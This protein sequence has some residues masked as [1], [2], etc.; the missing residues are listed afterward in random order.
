[1]TSNLIRTVIVDDEALA[2]QRLRHLLREEGDFDL[3]AECEGGA[4]AVGAIEFHDPDLVFLDVRMPEIDGFEVMARAGGDPSRAIVFVTAHEEYASRAFDIQA[5][6]YLLKPVTRERFREAAERARRR[7]ALERP[8]AATAIAGATAGAA[9]RYVERFLV[10]TGSRIVVVAT[11]EIEWVEGAG[12]YLKLHCGSANY[13]LRHTLSGFEARLDPQQFFRI[14][15][16]TIVR[17]DRLA[18]LES[19]ESGEYVVVLKNGTRLM[20]S[21]RYRGRIDRVLDQVQSSSPAAH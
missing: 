4:Q 3:V 9:P 18:A 16:S 1:V 6:D 14:H 2:R 21:R 20:M 12:N 19:R 13:L 5:V 11:S 7:V 17:I 8:A 15:R 10:R